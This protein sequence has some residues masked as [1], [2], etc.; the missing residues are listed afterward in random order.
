MGNAYTC[1]L[2]LGYCWYERKTGNFCGQQLIELSGSLGIPLPY[3]EKNVKSYSFVNTKVAQKVQYA[4]HAMALD[5]HRNLFTPT[6][7]ETPDQPHNLRKLKQCWFPGVHSNV[8]GS[9]ADAGIANITL[10]WMISQL[11]DTDGGLVLFSPAYLDYLQDLNNDRYATVPEPIR[12]WSMGRLYD[13]A[14]LNTANGIMQGISP[15]TRTPGRYF[16]PSF[17]DGLPTKQK[18][19]NTGECIHR[20]VRVRIN[21]GGKDTEGNADT[22]N[23]VKVVDWVKDATGHGQTKTYVCEALANF[24][25]TQPESLKTETDHSSRARS[26]V[27]WKAKDGGDPLYEDEMGETEVRMLK[28]SVESV[29]AKSA[30]TQVKSKV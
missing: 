16:R 29:K 4:F 19:K 21:S 24:E 18:L 28:R 7:W 3:N 30:T 13:S 11:E 2:C 5:E 8:G 27:V 23:V 26:A 22:S 6:L 1:S 17:E 14:P 25:L 15:I 20:S 9:Y 12:P 10:A